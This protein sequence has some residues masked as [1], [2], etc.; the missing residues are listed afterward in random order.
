MGSS[1]QNPGLEA[2]HVGPASGGTLVPWEPG[3]PASTKTM[4]R[5]ISA[6]VGAVF[7]ASA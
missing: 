7:S 3:V 2:D 6:T 5:S 1:R 4:T